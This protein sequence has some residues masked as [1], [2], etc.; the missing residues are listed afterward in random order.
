MEPIKPNAEELL[1]KYEGGVWVFLALVALAIL[2]LI[3]WLGY[4][5]LL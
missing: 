5:V 4:V 3:F 1:S 2:G